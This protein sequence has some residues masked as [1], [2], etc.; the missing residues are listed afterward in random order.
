MLDV[1]VYILNTYLQKG[2]LQNFT[3]Y[4]I[5]STIFPVGSQLPTKE[6]SIMQVTL[7]RKTAASNT[8][9]M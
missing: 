1:L 2:Q 4:I 6:R 3:H 8:A 9:L 5:L 7:A